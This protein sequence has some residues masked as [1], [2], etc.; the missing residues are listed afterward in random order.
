MIDADYAD[1]QV[2]LINT[3]AQVEFTLHTLE[4]AASSISLY[5]NANKTDYIY[6]KQKEA[7][8]SLMTSL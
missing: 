6:F 8:S 3:P 1:N 2:L 5:M 4:Q 7:I